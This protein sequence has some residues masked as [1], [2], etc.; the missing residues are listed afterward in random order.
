MPAVEEMINR[1][2][3]LHEGINCGWEQH[4]VLLEQFINDVL[5]SSSVEVDCGLGL[6]CWVLQGERYL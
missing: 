3:F 1:F 5:V 2:P 4:D 6:I